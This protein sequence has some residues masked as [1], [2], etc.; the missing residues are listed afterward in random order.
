MTTPAQAA[1]RAEN[2]R[3]NSTGPRTPEGKRASRANSLGHGGYATTIA[4]IPRGPLAEDPAVYEEFSDAVTASWNVEGP[5]EEEIART[6]ASLLWRGR[7]PRV[8]EAHY[9]AKGIDPRMDEVPTHGQGI[10]TRNETAARVLRSPASTH[11]TAEMQS[12]AIAVGHH[13]GLEMADDW[14]QPRPSTPAAW[15]ELI[16]QLLEESNSTRD[17]AAQGC[18]RRA[19]DGWANHAR[20][21]AQAYSRAVAK[22][23]E[24][25]LL[26]KT[27]RIEAHIGRELSR[28]IALLRALQA[29]RAP[30]DQAAD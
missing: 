21:E 19:A 8:Y 25:D 4:V 28:N 29:D 27:L 7:R 6:I 14:P 15:N 16:E 23:L 3:K 20:Q 17:L 26:L 2:G 22:V 5:V 9:L 13:I 24:D 11:S 30:T 12:A 18:D 1:A 10:A